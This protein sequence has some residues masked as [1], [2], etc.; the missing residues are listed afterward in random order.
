MKLNFQVQ[1]VLCQ[2]RVLFLIIQTKCLAFKLL[3]CDMGI[4]LPILTA[5]ENGRFIS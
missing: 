2:L 1:S 4:I 3:S 5:V